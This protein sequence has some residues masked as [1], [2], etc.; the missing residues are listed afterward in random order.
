MNKSIKTFIYKDRV[1]DPNKSC[2]ANITAGRIRWK[3]NFFWLF[4]HPLESDITC[5]AMDTKLMYSIYIA[6]L[7]WLGG[8]STSIMLQATCFYCVGHTTTN[9]SRGLRKVEGGNY[10]NWSRDYKNWSTQF[11]F[12]W[13]LLLPYGKELTHYVILFC[14]LC[15]FKGF[16]FFFFNFLLNASTQIILMC[17]KIGPSVIHQPK[18]SEV[19]EATVASSKFNPASNETTLNYDAENSDESQKPSLKSGLTEKL[20]NFD[21]DSEEGQWNTN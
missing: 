7:T 5:L 4:G 12:V 20:E 6:N 19:L 13:L 18:I 16:F 1:N 9:Q 17:L 2:S 11:F 10:K 14:L 21:I 3:N 8:I 15:L